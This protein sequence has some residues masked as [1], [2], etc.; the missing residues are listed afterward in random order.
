M[1]NI[2]NAPNSNGPRPA[3]YDAAPNFAL[4]DENGD[5]TAL[6][7]ILAKMDTIING[8]SYISEAINRIS[9]IAH[10]ADENGGDG[11][12]AKAIVE[13][14]TSREDTNQLALQMLEKMYNDMKPTKSSL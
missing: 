4:K 1:E 6:G 2:N 11:S 10:S 5:A 14:V 7:L 9:D 13:V 3:N 8:H 12:G